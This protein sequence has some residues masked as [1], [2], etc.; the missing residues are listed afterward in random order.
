MPL[1][2]NPELAD[3]PFILEAET[4]SFLFQGARGKRNVRNVHALAQRLGVLT[5]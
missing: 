2:V 1:E 5:G 4:N 3:Q